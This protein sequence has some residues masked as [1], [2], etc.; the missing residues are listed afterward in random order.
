V[1]QW[2][3]QAVEAAI[4]QQIINTRTVSGGDFAMAYQ[5]ELDDGES[6]F[7]KTHSDP[8]QNF[9]STEA[10]GLQW[11]HETNTVKIPEVL[12][13]SDDPPFLAMRW[14]EQGSARVEN[15]ETDTDL[16]LGAELA[17]LHKLQQPKFGRTDKRTTGSLALPNNPGDKWADFYASQRLRPLAKIAADRGALSNKLVD[18][19]YFIAD[20]L[21]NSD[22]AS[23][24]P[25]LLHG[26]LWAG[27][28][29]VDTRGQSWLI[30]PAVHCGH[31][32]FDLSMMLLFGGYSAACF[33]AYQNTHPLHDDFES[34]VPM[35]QLSPLVVH[36]IKFGDSYRSAVVSAIGDTRKLLV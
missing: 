28:R 31:R 15:M 7:V 33:K 22:I 1:S 16:T 14:V 25:S 6:I 9:F 11:L 26:D 4:G 5:C 29:I 35:H 8:P 13:Y 3:K 30:D 27:N 12:A 21:S 34:R 24:G 36:A 10:T 19:L 20:N 23:D 32:E 2:W 18:E 17:R